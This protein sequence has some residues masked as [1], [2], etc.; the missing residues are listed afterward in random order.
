A[1]ST[2]GRAS[3]IAP[4]AI[5]Q[6][7]FPHSQAAQASGARLRSTVINAN[8]NTPALPPLAQQ[9]ARGVGSRFRPRSHSPRGMIR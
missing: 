9:R 1:A 5:V 6:S 3:T 2:V 7:D 4:V 8:S